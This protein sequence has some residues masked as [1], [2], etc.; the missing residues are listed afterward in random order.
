MRVI[1]RILEYLKYRNLSPHAFEKACGI[2]NGYLKKQTKGKG[3]IGS[4]TL[5]KI[6]SLY[7][8]LSL[9]WLITGNGTM[10]IKD[11][12]ET[13]DEPKLLSEPELTYSSTGTI[14]V[15]KEKIAMLE[16]SLA[17]KEKIIALL[18]ARCREAGLLQP[19]H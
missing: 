18:E 6:T 5:E 7:R 17:D 19:D 9:T 15:L 1:D 3:T 11:Y 12:T 16:K 13:A 2:A 4:E 10:L 8:D 14:A